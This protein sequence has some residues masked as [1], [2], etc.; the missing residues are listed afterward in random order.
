MIDMRL[1][2]LRLSVKSLLTNKFKKDNASVFDQGMLLSDIAEVT[3][4]IVQMVHMNF[5][6]DAEEFRP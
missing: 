5:V 3:D 2:C 6:P 1:H 4:E